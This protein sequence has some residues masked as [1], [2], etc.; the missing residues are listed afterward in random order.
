RRGW[1]GRFSM[2]HRRRLR[3]VGPGRCAGLRNLVGE[4]WTLRRGPRC[5][6]LACRVGVDVYRVLGLASGRVEHRPLGR[7][8]TRDDIGATDGYAAGAAR[9]RSLASLSRPDVMAGI[10]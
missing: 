1:A 4:R 10:D 7:R 9:D 6:R 2:G 8:P 5:G 3:W